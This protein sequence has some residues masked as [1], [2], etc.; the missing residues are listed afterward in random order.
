[1]RDYTGRSIVTRIENFGARRTVQREEQRE[2]IAELQ[3][4]RLTRNPD[5]EVGEKKRGVLEEVKKLEGKPEWKAERDR[6]EREAEE[7]GRGYG[8][9][10]M[11][12][13]WEVWSWG[14]GKSKEDADEKGERDDNN[15]KKGGKR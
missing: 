6:K 9:L 11:D 10:I 3:R 2:K 8:D 13:V 15:E 12:Q 7:E 4:E 14:K 5:V 1:M